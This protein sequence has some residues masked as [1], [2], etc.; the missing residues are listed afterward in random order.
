MYYW[1]VD[2]AC[3]LGRTNSNYT[4]LVLIFA[5]SI[6][7]RFWKRDDLTLKKKV[8]LALN[9]SHTITYTRSHFL[10]QRE[11]IMHHAWTTSTSAIVL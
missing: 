3:S 10:H 1:L 2:I 11:L 8:S 6:G 7:R 9:C 4:V 5:D